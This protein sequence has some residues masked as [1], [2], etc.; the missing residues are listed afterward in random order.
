M[1]WTRGRVRKSRK[2]RQILEAWPKGRGT[3]RRPR[4]K[5][6]QG[7]RKIDGIEGIARKNGGVTDLSNVRGP[8]FESQFRQEL[9]S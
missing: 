8:R 1:V 6:N 3:K 2:P 7:K 9:F 5:E 4:E